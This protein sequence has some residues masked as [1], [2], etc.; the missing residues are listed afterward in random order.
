[1]GYIDALITQNVD[2]LH[3][4]ALDT[5]DWSRRGR[6]QRK[7][8]SL[9]APPVYSSPPPTGARFVSR[10][11]HERL[12]APLPLEL[13]GTLHT[14]RCTSTGCTY[15]AT[16]SSFQDQLSALNPDWFAFAQ[17]ATAQGEE[18]RTNPDGDVDLKNKTYGDFIYPTCPVCYERAT[19]EPGKTRRMDR[20]R[21]E[22]LSKDGIGVMK[23]MFESI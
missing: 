22:G 11:D 4:R 12:K 3:H 6:G 5:I 15:V 16:R 19:R 2:R 10:H 7:D 8:T 13:H 9:I 1:M 18:P 20:D 23:R 14:V 21:E 17:R